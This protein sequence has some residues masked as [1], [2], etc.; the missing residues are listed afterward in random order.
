MKTH[1][2]DLYNKIDFDVEIF[3]SDQTDLPDNVLF[4]ILHRQVVDDDEEDR[5]KN[6]FTYY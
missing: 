4:G 1:F 5:Y 2:P 3:D 6:G